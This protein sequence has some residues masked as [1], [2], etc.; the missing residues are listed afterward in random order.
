[1]AFQKIDSYSLGFKSG[2][3]AAGLAGAA[4][5]VAL[6]WAVVGRLAVIRSLRLSAG[7]LVGFTAGFATFDLIRANGFS[8]A[9]T[10]GAAVAW[11][12]TTS[13]KRRLTMTDSGLSVAASA[14][15]EVRY[16]ETA[17]LSAGTRTL[18]TNPISVIGTSVAAT[19]G[20]PLIP[21]M[22]ELLPQYPA[23]PLVLS[24]AS[25]AL[26]EGLILRATVP[27]T[28]TWQFSVAMDWEEYSEY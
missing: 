3:M 10:G 14:N 7:S 28:G 12:A 4:P 22:T 25:G 2:T 21:P 1:M 20:A 23:Y 13:N 5:I 27:A 8:A 18:D 15:G 9:D 24:A 16:S 6:R 17:T 11:T 19:A 26:A